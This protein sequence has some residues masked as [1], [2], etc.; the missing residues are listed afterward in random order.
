MPW[1]VELTTRIASASASRRISQRSAFAGAPYGAV[2]ADI[3]ARFVGDEISRADLGRLC[4][5]A[6]ATFDHAA[7]APLVQLAP[8]RFLLELFHGPTLAF[9]VVAM[10]VLARLYEHVL[11]ASGRTI[12]AA[13]ISTLKIVA[14]RTCSGR[15]R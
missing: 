4:A 11:A 3:L 10:Q 5:D 6:Y 15:C 1:L 13:A 14:P 2:A 8:G 12:S 9:K 7:V